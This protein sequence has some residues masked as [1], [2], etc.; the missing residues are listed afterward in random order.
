MDFAKL[1]INEILSSKI[2]YVSYTGSLVIEIRIQ[3]SEA[4]VCES[5]YLIHEKKQWGR[6]LEKTCEDTL[7]VDF[8]TICNN[9]Q[10]QLQI[11][12]GSGIELAR[13][14]EGDKLPESQRG[15]RPFLDMEYNFDNSRS[16]WKTVLNRA[17][18]FWI[19]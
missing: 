16:S 14:I 3:G 15:C 11:Y 9:F 8:E 12:T 6:G 7:P 10:N 13:V 4:R 2:D 19:K 18:I 1:H 5:A 17:T